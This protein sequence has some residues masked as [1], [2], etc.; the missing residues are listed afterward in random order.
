MKKFVLICM[1]LFA[2]DFEL[3]AQGLRLEMV[4]IY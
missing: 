4:N 1:S 2:K 3:R